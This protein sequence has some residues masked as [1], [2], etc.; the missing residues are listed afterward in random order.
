[1]RKPKATD[2]LCVSCNRSGNSFSIFNP[3]NEETQKP[4]PSPPTPTPHTPNSKLITNNNN[5][6][7]EENNDNNDKSLKVELMKMINSKMND[8][9][10]NNEQ[11]S[12]SNNNNITSQRLPLLFKEKLMEALLLDD[13][14]YPSLLLYHL[15]AR[16]VQLLHSVNNES[17][18]LPPHVN[19]ELQ[20]ISSLRNLLL[21]S[22]TSLQ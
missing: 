3:K 15:N 2:L 7:N 5:I 6:D 22:I 20:F 1:M 13:S 18:A 9:L 14:I 21:S 4:T 10:Q 16:A 8:E 17:S 12:R 11:L 19:D